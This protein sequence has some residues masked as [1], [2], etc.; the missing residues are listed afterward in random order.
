[1]T[2]KRILL[3]FTLLTLTLLRGT[4]CKHRIITGEDEFNP[5]KS[6]HIDPQTG[7]INHDRVVRKHNFLFVTL[8]NLE[9][10]I[11]STE[12]FVL[13]IYGDWCDFSKKHY[14]VFQSFARFHSSLHSKLL[15]GKLH[16]ARKEQFGYSDIRSNP[17]I[18]L[19]H[20]GHLLRTIDFLNSK[21]K[22]TDL[23]PMI[24]QTF[25]P[26]FIHNIEHVK[27]LAQITG[28]FDRFLIFVSDGNI[29]PKKL[30]TALTFKQEAP[31][32]SGENIQINEDT[33]KGDVITLA[34]GRTGQGNSV[35]GIVPDDGRTQP[36][37]VLDHATKVFANYVLMSDM[38]FGSHLKFFAM[39]T[40]EHLRRMFPEHNIGNGHVYLFR[41]SDHS[42]L[43]VDLLEMNTLTNW[44]DLKSWLY[45]HLHSHVLQFPQ[46]AKKNIINHHNMA[47]FLFL[48]SEDNNSLALGANEKAESELDLAAKEL[49]KSLHLTK[50]FIDR[51]SECKR[52]Y[53]N[54]FQGE[55][56]TDSK[57]LLRLI[58]PIHD[59]RGR[60]LMIKYPE[61]TITSTG[62]KAFI[63]KF[64]SNDSSLQIDMKSQKP[65][66]PKSK[67]YQH[68]TAKEAL[69]VL[70]GNKS[71]KKDS[72]VL[73]YRGSLKRD[74]QTRKQ[75]MGLARKMGKLANCDVKFFLYDVE[76]NAGIMF[77]NKHKSIPA[78]SLF[79]K[80]YDLQK[81][82][83]L[84]RA[85]N[86][87]EVLLFVNDR[88][89]S[90]F[91]SFFQGYE[92]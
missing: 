42:L 22:I 33:A 39:N 35:G 64:R 63:Q 17:S 69:S 56:L 74:K 79:R 55:D 84:E 20:K 45:H 50:C 27:H 38:R 78:V 88:L 46:P 12:Y 71:A 49:Y 26:F 30:K 40:T 68:L 11:K 52:L 60:Q 51:D 13:F 58:V 91:S 67:F 54:N 31:V 4:T 92:Y 53:T 90:D 28:T 21:V 47:L 73:F 89:H 86:F 81:Y 19:Y 85:T 66:K 25:Q 65:Q 1:M 18:L 9:K 61:D 77:R 32:S 5:N 16:I 8:K 3:C 23:R 24:L 7:K 34:E 75:F 6:D 29:S 41:A 36:G 57:P 37:E 82:V 72:L 2:N 83:T 80:D 59:L 15:F 76:K 44:F 48:H 14:K 70:R 10:V 43:R 87:K 62:I